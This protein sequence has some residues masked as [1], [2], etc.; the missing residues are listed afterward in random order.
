[1]EE[2]KRCNEGDTKRL[3]MLVSSS[4]VVVVIRLGAKI[5]KVVDL[6]SHTGG[7]ETEH[8]AALQ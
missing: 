3:A 6:G 8:P 4:S 2:L 5:V 1:M 7:I